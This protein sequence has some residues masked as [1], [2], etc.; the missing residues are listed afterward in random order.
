MN[1]LITET[2]TVSKMDSPKAHEIEEDID[3]EMYEC[4]AKLKVWQIENLMAP[5][6]MDRFVNDSCKG[7]S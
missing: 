6:G 3:R 7:P 4:L 5:H 2:K 1:E